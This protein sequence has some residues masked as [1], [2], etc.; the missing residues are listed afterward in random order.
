MR[1][2][3]LSFA[4]TTEDYRAFNK[5][6]VMT[7]GRYRDGV[8]VYQWFFAIAAGALVAYLFADISRGVQMGAGLGVLA[9]VAVFYP[10]LAQRNALRAMGGEMSKKEY[11]PLYNCQRVLETSD[12]GIRSESAVGF[13]LVRWRFIE[14]V[15]QTDKHAFI[16]FPGN[17]GWVIPKV[18]VEP[19]ALE[20]FLA[21]IKMRIAQAESQ[22]GSPDV[23]RP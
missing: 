12:E 17:S 1:M 18:L 5:H 8:F 4:T 21:E 10:R 13:Q 9:L 23:G 7:N 11:Q 16:C 22:A 6:V 3:R 19:S 2:M 15:H 14:A 20:A